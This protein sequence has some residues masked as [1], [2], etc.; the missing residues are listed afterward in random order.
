MKP[1]MLAVAIWFAAVSGCSCPGGVSAA[2]TRWVNCS[3]TCDA[4]DCAA[5][6]PHALRTALG[7]E[8]ATMGRRI[9][10]TI[11]LSCDP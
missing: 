7:T 8:A 9:S 11:D 3:F 1:E 2:A 10:A 6:Q 4:G 5:D